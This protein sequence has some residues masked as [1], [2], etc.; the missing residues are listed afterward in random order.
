MFKAGIDQDAI[1]KMVAQAS[2]QQGEVLRKAVSEAMLKALQAREL[3]L[4]NIRGVLET[5]TRATSVGAANSALPAVDVR[6]LLSKALAGMDAALL[7]AVQAHRKVLQQF[8]DQ[9]AELQDP[10]MKD[11]LADIEKMEDLFLTTVKNASQEAEARLRTAWEQVISTLKDKGTS[12]G[13]QAATSIE[14]LMSQAQAALRAG[15]TAGLR[16]VQAM[17]E[18]Y[19]TLASGVLIGISQTLA[20]GDK[21][22]DAP[23]DRS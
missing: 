14:E 15:G 13:A 23:Q 5:V 11:A 8:V 3:T 6:N 7:Q 22:A 2:A 17:L 19:A 16:G 4:A 20:T 21:I 1:I 9:G 12:T 10:K 18:S